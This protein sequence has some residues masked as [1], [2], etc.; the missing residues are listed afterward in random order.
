MN[1]RAFFR[2]LG[3]SVAAIP[4]VRAIDPRLPEIKSPPRTTKFIIGDLVELSRPARLRGMDWAWDHFKTRRGFV[5][6][7]SHVDSY[8]YSVTG[9]GAWLGDDELIMIKPF[10]PEVFEVVKGSAVHFRP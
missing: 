5:S 10:P 2:L 8:H 4:L 6:E 9:V 3:L 1:R 7:V